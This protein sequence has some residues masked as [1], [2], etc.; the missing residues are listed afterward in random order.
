MKEPV[1]QRGTDTEEDPLPLT[2]PLL[3]PCCWLGVMVR[4]LLPLP[5]LPVPPPPL[6]AGDGEEKRLRFVGLMTPDIPLTGPMLVYVNNC[7]KDNDNNIDKTNDIKVRGKGE[8]LLTQSLL[9]G[10]SLPPSPP[11]LSLSLT[12]FF[13]VLFLMANITYTHPSITKP[14]LNK[15]QHSV[16]W[17]LRQHWRGE[18]GRERERNLAKESFLLPSSSSSSLLSAA[19][20]GDTKFGS[21]L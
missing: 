15:S 19:R 2:L 5:P 20:A 3:V 1:F 17:L 21:Y 11:L 10:V 4:G 8:R 18:E 12:G 7:E 6:L 16:K 13:L 14:I 9:G